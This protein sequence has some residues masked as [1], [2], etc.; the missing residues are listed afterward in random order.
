[1]QRRERGE[2]RQVVEDGLGHPNRCGVVKATMDDAV[3]EG[4]E[5]LLQRRAPGGKDL[6]AGG[7]MVEAFAGGSVLSDAAP[8]R[9]RSRR[10]ATPIPSI[11]PRKRPSSSLAPRT[12]RI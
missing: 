7:V 8:C 4:D 10:G 1:M 12:A 9:P 6:A 3:A 2:P 11:C 5:T